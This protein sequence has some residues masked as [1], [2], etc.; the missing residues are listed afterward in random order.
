MNNTQKGIYFAIAAAILSGFSIFLNKFAVTAI[1][2]PLVFTATKNFSVGLLIIGI[3]I[4]TKKWRLFKEIKKQDFLKLTLIGIIGGSLPFYLFFTGLSQTSAIN[5]AMI[6]KSL[7]FWVAILAFPLLKEKLSRVQILAISLL[8]ISNYFVGGFSGFQ[9]SQAEAMILLATILWAGETIL[10]KK[11][12]PRVDPD[13]VLAFRMGL[14]SLILLSASFFAYPAS[15]LQ[16]TTL[17]SVQL[18][19]LLLTAII[20]FAYVATWYRALKYAPA[21]LV[22]AILVSS[23]LITNLLSAIFITHSLPSVLLS[24]QSALVLSGLAFLFVFSRETTQKLQKAV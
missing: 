3:I 13:I 21:I 17:T 11:L 23:T 9:F 2:P 4:A 20:L 6:H 10:V 5:G 8:F 15:V 12:L 7:V 1:T 24:S 14:G 18:F 16:I 19:W 22:S